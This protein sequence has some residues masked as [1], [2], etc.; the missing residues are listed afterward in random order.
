MHALR[1]SSY[2]NEE[3]YSQNTHRRKAST[4]TQ[5]SYGEKNLFWFIELISLLIP[6]KFEA[7]FFASLQSFSF[8]IDK[9]YTYTA[10]QPAVANAQGYPFVAVWFLWEQVHI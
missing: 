9:K 1:S 6:L 3:I 8:E 7:L 5:M 4:K 2:C 10:R